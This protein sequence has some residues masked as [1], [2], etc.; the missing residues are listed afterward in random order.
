MR[1]RIRLG[2]ARRFSRKQGKNRHIAGGVGALLNPAS[3]VAATLAV[4]IIAADLGVASQ[5][6][7]TQG[8]FSHWQVWAVTAAAI[9]GVAWALDEYARRHEAPLGK[10]V[11][12]PGNRNPANPLE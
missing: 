9:K 6:A 4:W 10:P 12:L 8:F 11:G 3:L 5:F 7:I 2:E 1:L